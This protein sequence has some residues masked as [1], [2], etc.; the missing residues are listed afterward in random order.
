[1]FKVNKSEFSVMMTITSRHV[2][3]LKKWPKHT[4]TKTRQFLRSIFLLIA[5]NAPQILISL[6]LGFRLG[7]AP[8]KLDLLRSQ[9][10]SYQTP[11]NPQMYV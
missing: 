5:Q 4:K 2:E 9:A 6:N 3:A 7:G 11:A 1:M 8:H 10:N